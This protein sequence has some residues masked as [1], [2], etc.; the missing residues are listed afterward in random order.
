MVLVSEP[1]SLDEFLGQWSGELDLR[2]GRWTDAYL[3][4]FAMASGCRL[5]AFDDDFSRFPGLAFLHVRI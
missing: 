2:R 5:V 1:A 4:A 3:A